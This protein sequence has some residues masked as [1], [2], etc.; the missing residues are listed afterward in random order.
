M[1][2]SMVTIIT[3]AS[4]WLRPP[5]DAEKEDGNEDCSGNQENK[6][7]FNSNNP[8]FPNKKYKIQ[9]KAVKISYVSLFLNL[10]MT[11]AAI[12]ERPQL[13]FKD[14]LKEKKYFFTEKTD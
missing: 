10:K 5:L 8:R 3:D 1:K 13:V 9:I 2:K 11:L 14:G 12:I 7:L 6:L 4:R